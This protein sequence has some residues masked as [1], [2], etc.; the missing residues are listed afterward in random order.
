M[1]RM[2]D[3]PATVIEAARATLTALLAL[4]AASRDVEAAA[5]GDLRFADAADCIKHISATLHEIDDDTLIKLADVDTLSEGG[6]SK[7]IASRLSEVGFDLPLYR[8]ATAFFA[9]VIEQ[10]EKILQRARQNLN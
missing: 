6:L 8:D 3:E 10:V 9:P 4:Y 1:H 7:L 5:S 2:T